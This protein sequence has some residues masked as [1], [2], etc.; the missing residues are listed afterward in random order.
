MGLFERRSHLVHLR[1]CL[2]ERDPWLQPRDRLKV[3]AEAVRLPN[4][5]VRR[6][7]VR[8][9]EGDGPDGADRIREVGRHDADNLVAPT[10]Q[11]NRTSDDRGISAESTT[12]ECVAQDGDAVTAV[13]FV[14]RREGAPDRRMGP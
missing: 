5:F 3:K 6:N 10:F 4:P 9:P 14:L 11:R 8:H 12:P 1:L 13:D 7:D 2:L